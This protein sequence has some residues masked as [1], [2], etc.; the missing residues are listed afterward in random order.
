M[1]SKPS[2]LIL[3]IISEK[4]INPYELTK[5]L[6]Y[7]NIKNWFY[8]GESSIYSTIKTLQSKG[9]ITGENIKEGN[10]PEKTVYSITP[11]G[12]IE[13]ISALEDFLGNTDLDFVKFNIAVILICHLPKDR[14]LALLENK[15][16]SLKEKLAI[17]QEKL[18]ALSSAE[19]SK[20]V[21]AIRHII[22]LTKADILSTEEFIALVQADNDWNRF[23][24]KDIQV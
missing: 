7:I 6:E 22:H 9:Y 3:G 18:E 2:V 14:V 17:Q 10:M 8:I 1:L 5:F 23:L 20:G 16:V 4:A 11:K 24:A 13:L 21:H 19:T 12:E 15:I